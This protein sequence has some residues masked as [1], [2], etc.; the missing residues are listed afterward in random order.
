MPL[1]SSGPE[2]G[3]REPPAEKAHSADSE[4]SA[5]VVARTLG[6]LEL[7]I[8]GREVRE[9]GSQKGRGVLQ[10]LLLSGGRPVRR[11]TL[12]DLLWPGH[13]RSTARNNLNVALY[14]LR[15][16]VVPSDQSGGPFIEHRQG[17]YVLSPGLSW[18]IDRDA[19]LEAW[20][21]GTAAH[22]ASDADGALF[23]YS[24]AVGLYRGRLF[25]DDPTGEW[26]FAEQRLIE[27]RYLVALERLASLQ[28]AAG[29]VEVAEATLQ[30]ALA[31]DACRESTHRLLMQCYAE[32]HQH[33]LVTRQ[34]HLCV[35]SLQRELGI[36]PDPE[37]I[38]RFRAV[39]GEE[40]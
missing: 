34:F 2:G 6:N 38:R 27:E 21:R 14:A 15:R 30:R 3:L 23:G 39:M 10:Y 24:R 7:V 17:S 35:D 33:Q 26:L 29:D 1:I 25:E 9:W 20:T 19:F 11:E 13:N 37:T 22:S 16:A 36:A 31:R 18:W 4:Y 8:H 12:M 5:D 32:L 28:L 40:R